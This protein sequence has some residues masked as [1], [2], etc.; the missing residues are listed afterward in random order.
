MLFQ[1]IVK[2]FYAVWCS[3]LGIEYTVHSKGPAGSVTRHYNMAAKSNF[4]QRTQSS[5]H[6]LYKHIHFIFI[7]A[8][9]TWH[10]QMACFN[11]DGFL[12]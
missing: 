12:G 4:F 9:L 1:T 7:K 2:I 6:K 5:L 3:E 10:I 8:I 11:K